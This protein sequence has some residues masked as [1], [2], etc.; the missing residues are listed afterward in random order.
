MR[1]STIFASLALLAITGV[2]GAQGTQKTTSHASAVATGAKMAGPADTTAH[3]V[4][5][6]RRRRH[7]NAK[8]TP[9]PATKTDSVAA[10]PSPMASPKADTK[11]PCG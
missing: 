9:K 6:S 1:S 7:R 3:A 4:N 2:A 10:K 5:K 8:S 11:K